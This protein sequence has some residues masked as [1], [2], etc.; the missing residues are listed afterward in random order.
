M[1]RFK[2]LYLPIPA[3]RQTGVKL[4]FFPL[5]FQWELPNALFQLMDLFWY[6]TLSPKKHH[7]G[8]ILLVRYFG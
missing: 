3:G 8:I 4:V 5:K 2:D 6:I 7:V 1:N